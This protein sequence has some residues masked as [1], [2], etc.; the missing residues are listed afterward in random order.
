MDPDGVARPCGTAFIH[1]GGSHR[2]TIAPSECSLVFLTHLFLFYFTLFWCFVSLLHVGT[3]PGPLHMSTQPPRPLRNLSAFNG[4]R[5]VC[6]MCARTPGPNG[7]N[8]IDEHMRN[9]HTHREVFDGSYG[10][11]MRSRPLFVRVRR[12]VRCG[13]IIESFARTPSLGFYF[14]HIRNIRTRE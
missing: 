12:C 3:W 9:I 2:Q 8:A 7:K 1:P 10:N 11:T 14:G 5:P 13:R 6:L 4:T